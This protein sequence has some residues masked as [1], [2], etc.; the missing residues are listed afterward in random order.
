MKL[1][2]LF[3]ALLLLSLGLPLIGQ[4]PTSAPTTRPRF[5]IIPPPGMNIVTV[6]Q[7]KAIAEPADE[8][9]VKEVLTKTVPATRPSTMPADVTAAVI[10]KRG[11]VATA[12]MAELGINDKA[13]VDKMFDERILG[14]LKKLQGINPP[15]FYLATSGEKFKELVKGGWDKDHYYYNRVADAVTTVP[16]LTPG[17]ADQPDDQLILSLWGKDADASMKQRILEAY[18]LDVESRIVN[19]MAGDAQNIVRV[20]IAQLIDEAAFKDIEFKQGQ[21]WLALG[22]RDAI[23]WK[24]TSMIHGVPYQP[25]LVGE[26][27]RNPF[28]AMSIDLLHPTPL[29]Q[30]REGAAPYYQDAIR[31]RAIHVFHDWQTKAPKDAI[32]KV[33]SAMRAQKPADGEA[34]L[35]IIKD[36]SGIDLADQLKAY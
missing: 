26:D 16:L 20:A 17:P 15:I 7:R 22:L 14:N 29:N 27:Q 12:L 25:E 36:A 10:A 6:N 19:A 35:K 23:S 4:T 13:A 32:G 18:V 33:L 9:W 30:L 5:A 2:H 21:E 31:R 8:P 28:R 24:Y 11:A 34:L 3:A 1:T